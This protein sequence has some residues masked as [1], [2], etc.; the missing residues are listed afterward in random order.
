[1]EKNIS[2]RDFLKRAGLAVAASVGM[3]AGVGCSKNDNI[4]EEDSQ[5]SINKLNDY[6]LVINS[7]NE[8][9]LFKYEYVNSNKKDLSNHF[10]CYYLSTNSPKDMTDVLLYYDY[11]IVGISE[12]ILIDYVHIMYNIKED[13]PASIYFIDE[14]GL[15]DSYSYEEVTELLK[16]APEK[17]EENKKILRK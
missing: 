13:V 14:Y 4:E 11:D 17:A 15:K 7:D 12:E 2:R 10:H 3:A 5:I 6:N 1:M 8:A 9:M 16:K